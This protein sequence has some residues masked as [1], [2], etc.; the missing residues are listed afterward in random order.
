VVGL[1]I[2]GLVI[3]VL[4][5]YAVDRALKARARVRR[6]RA[7]SDRLAAAATRAEEQH[8][9]RQAADQAS[10]ALTSV[11]PAINR[12]PLTLPGGP[13]HG[14]TR[15]RTGCE[16]T[17]PQDHRTARPAHPGRPSRAGHDH[18]PVPQSGPDRDSR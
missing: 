5:L 14:A 2:V 10:A 4:V 16:R 18:T 8:E 3:A 11:M 12:P 15:P 1:L 7:M 9:R 13:P 17:G 6:V